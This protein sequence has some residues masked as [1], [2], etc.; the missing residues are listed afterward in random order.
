MARPLSEDK[1]D[2][3]LASAAE[4]VAALGTGAPTARIARGAG[5]AEG[6]L[7]TY[8]PDKDAL[9]AA[10]FLDL[11]AELAAAL[12]D[13]V[14]AGL[15]PR[16]RI[17]RMWDRLID[18]SA[19]NPVRLKALK[20]LKVSDRIGAESRRCGEQLFAD[21]RTMLDAALAGHARG[22]SADYVGAVLN[23]LAETTLDFIARDP[24]RHDH[25]RAL[26]FETFWKA[27]AR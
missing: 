9:L 21:F 19:A 20:Q 3:I 13:N 2:A 15:R 26:G 11:E 27:I 1:R 5:V 22:L 25:H 18:W 4:L 6:T 12:L 16:E 17:R 23:A 14:P 10:L 24:G 7:F 8:F